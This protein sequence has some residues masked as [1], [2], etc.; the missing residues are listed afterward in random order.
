[1]LLQTASFDIF[2]KTLCHLCLGQFW[3][4]D[5]NLNNFSCV[6]LTMPHAKYL[7]SKLMVSGKSNTIVLYIFLITHVTILAQ[8]V[9]L[10]FFV[11][12][13]LAM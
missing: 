8:N 2:F 7:S 11:K 5:D 3:S 13:L 1:M 6:H 9:I 4:E 12:I 10:T